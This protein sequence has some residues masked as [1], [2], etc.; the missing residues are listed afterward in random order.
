[1]NFRV[2]W[3]ELGLFN[4][5]PYFPHF[6]W[7]SVQE[8]ATDISAEF[9]RKRHKWD[10]TFLPGANKVTFM[11]VPY[12]VWHSDSEHRLGKVREQPHRVHHLQA[13]YKYAGLTRGFQLSPRSRW[14]FHFLN[15]IY[16]AA[17]FWSCKW[18]ETCSCVGREAH[19]FTHTG[20]ITQRD[21]AH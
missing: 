3:T 13:S 15:L 12:N 7:N 18:A 9:S 20:N 19:T 4:I 10:L 11:P 14:G 21:D 5:Y 6:P 8:T 17:W 1:M 2:P 16:V